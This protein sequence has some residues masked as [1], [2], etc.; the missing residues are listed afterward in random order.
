MVGQKNK[1]D[2]PMPV[3]DDGWWMSVLAEESRS[4]MPLPAHLAGSRPEVGEETQT[5]SLEKK[6]VTDWSQVKDLYMRDQIIDLTV[7][8]HNRGG[9]LVEGD[10][11]HGF[12]P[13]SHLV[14]LAGKVENLERSRDLESYLG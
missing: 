9:L 3:I 13:S 10:G 8:G 1:L 2:N 7:T 11:L 12:V 5:V 6:L 4:A 14:D